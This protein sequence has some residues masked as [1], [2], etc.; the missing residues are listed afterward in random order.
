MANKQSRLAEIYK[1]EKSKGGGVFSTLA[2]GAKEK[3]DPRQIF[4]QKGFAAAVLPSLFKAYSATS[5]KSPE[6]SGQKIA[7]L[8]GS[9]S[10]GVLETKIDA[11]TNEARDIKIHS[12]MSAKNS[13]VLPS[14]ARDMNLIR[15]NIGKLVKLQGGTATT[16]A[17]MFFKRAGERES[18]YESKYAKAG[19][20]PSTSPTK[21]G[22]I[23]VEKK[24][25]FLEELLGFIPN[26]LKLLGAA[27]LIGQL[28]KI[29]AV[30]EAVQNFV[31]GFLEKFFDG[32]KDFFSMVSESLKDPK[33]QE[34]IAGVGVVD[35]CNFSHSFFLIPKK[36]LGL[37]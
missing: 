34:S 17:D 5:S 14:M 12:K 2:K 9:F 19:G 22:Q 4:N 36:F 28:L 20:L 10:T 11:L 1:S 13:I 37:V 15:L 35:G 24:K 30:K 29:P 23:L 31:T 21:E 18:A 3:F 8:S 6:S 32:I 27:A 7:S 33:V 26:F 25:S 16:K